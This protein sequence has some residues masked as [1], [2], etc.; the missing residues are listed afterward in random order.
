MSQADNHWLP[1]ADSHPP[2][3]HSAQPPRREAEAFAPPAALALVV[4]RIEPEPM[5]EVMSGIFAGLCELLDLLRP[6]DEVL[7]RGDAG[8]DTTPAF[9]LVNRKSRAL[10][11]YVQSHTLRS[12]PD[13]ALAETLD[14]TCFA[15]RHELG[16]V[17]GASPAEWGAGGLSVADAGRACGLLKNCFQQSVLALAQ[18]F[19]PGLS[20]QTLFS[21]YRLRLEQ[22]LTLYAEL[23]QLSRLA[24]AA[25]AGGGLH[26]CLSFAGRL[27][28][29][30]AEHLH[31]L[32]YRDWNEF[33][34]SAER[35]L[36]AGSFEQLRPLLHQFG[37]YLETLIGHVRMRAVLANHQIIEG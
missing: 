26:A 27:R 9:R 22:S 28:A 4:A 30:R 23:S 16:R 5:R 24:R 7:L 3:G 18:H 8:V 29:F 10:L 35:L 2:G 33:E 36:A 34:E 20:G 31:L 25:E 12:V 14:A 13:H 1:R 17:F 19:S 21:D 15:L 32:M 11:A 6:V 37:R